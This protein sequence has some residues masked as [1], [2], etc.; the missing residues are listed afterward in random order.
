MSMNQGE[1]ILKA[2]TKCI[3][4]NGYAQV[5]LRDIAKEADV[6]LSQVNYYYKNKEGLFIEVI[7]NLSKRYL[8][9]IEEC[10]K[11]GKSSKEKLLDLSN[12][13]KENIKNKPEVIKLLFDFINMSIW[14]KNFSGQ[15]NSL[16]K[17]ISELIEKYVVD[18]KIF[19]SINMKKYSQ[20]SFARMILG[21]F[22][23]TS[24]QIILD[25]EKDEIFEALNVTTEML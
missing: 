24:M 20:S 11:V 18:E 8:I 16:F 4:H 2:A 6:V 22:L 17:E 9:E 5:S 21:V 10:L 19:K 7:K 13:F 14:S 3:M 25:P 23:G 15:L 12:Y 1:R